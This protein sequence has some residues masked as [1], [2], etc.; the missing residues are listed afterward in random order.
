MLQQNQIIVNILID[1]VFF[2]QGIHFA[3]S[4]I[5]KGGRNKKRCQLNYDKLTPLFRLYIL[6]IYSSGGRGFW[7]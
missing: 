2:N 3:N 5:A 7:F 1:S 6:K 4:I